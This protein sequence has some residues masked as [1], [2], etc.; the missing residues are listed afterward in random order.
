[1]TPDQFHNIISKQLKVLPGEKPYQKTYKFHVKQK[2]HNQNIIDYFTSN[3]GYIPKENWI[4]KIETNNLTVN[5]QPVSID[6]ILQLGDFVSHQTLVSSEPL[7]SKNIDLVYSCKDYIVISKPAPLPMHGCGRYQKNTLENFLKLSFPEMEL[8]ITH[9][10]DSNTTGLV[11]LA[12]NNP[13]AQF[14]NK[15]FTEHRIQKTYLAWVEGLIEEK[16]FVLKQSF[17]TQKDSGG[18]RSISE[19]GIEAETSFELLKTKENK[20]LL[21]ISPKTGKTNQIRLHLA[22]IGHPI[23]GDVGYKDEDYFKNNPFTYPE[24]TLFL[25]AW[26][27]QFDDVDGSTKEFKSPIPQKFNFTE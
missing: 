10:L 4:H 23:I 20:S 6:Y 16:N 21:K 14:F 18:K 1:M 3:F 24:D 13:T 8:K 27:L 15:L 19:T 5:K 11:I 26:K 25:H 12:K 17:D 9:R 7:V 22:N 2:G